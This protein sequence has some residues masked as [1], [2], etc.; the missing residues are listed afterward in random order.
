MLY[1]ASQVSGLTVL[2]PQ[3]S[4]H[5]TPY[6]Y[7]IRGRLT[8]L[9]FG[10]P[11]DDFDLLMDEE[12]GQPVLWECYP[13]A[14]QRIYGGKACSLYAVKEEGFLAGKTGWEPELVCPEHVSVLWEERIPDLFLILSQAAEA[15]ESP[16]YQAMLREELTWRIRQ[17]GLTRAQ[18]NAERRFSEAL[19]RLLFP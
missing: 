9:C 12:E 2:L 14:F 8:A 1:H 4:T 13:G 15:G 7:A 16:E 17:L 6:V 18:L 10:A 3:A 11:K 19:D 5:Q